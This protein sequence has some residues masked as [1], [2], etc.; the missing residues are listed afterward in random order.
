M[1]RIAVIGAGGIAR[2]VHLPSLMA[3][4]D[5]HVCAVCD[6]YIERAESA[7]AGFNA[8]CYDNYH[9][10]LEREKPDGV[11][12]LVQPDQSYRIVLDCMRFGADVFCEKPA[13]ITLFQLESLAKAQQECGTVLQIGFNRRYIPLVRAVTEKMK[14]LGG[15]IVQVGGSFFKNGDASFYSGCAS[16]LECDVI[17][18]ADLLCWFAGSEA[19]RVKA[20][21]GRVNSDVDNGWNA[22]LQFENGV[23]GTIRSN[24]QT[25][26]RTHGF[27]LH[28]PL[29]SAYIN[30]GFG[31]A[32]CE[33][34]MIYFG[35]Q[36]SFSL[37]STGTQEEHIEH[38]DGR[39][40]AGSGEYYR[41]YGY[42]D[43]DSAFVD[44]MKS[45]EAPESD[46]QSAIRAMRLTEAIMAD[47]KG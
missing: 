46:I 35:G 3:I 23:L 8:K 32:A 12:V 29:A 7:A 25:G 36:K 26:G 27:E 34:D 17:H 11:F 9:T 1:K 5:I 42:Y 43:E 41:Y 20:L 16:A 24:Y 18:V 31:T 38:F 19:Q 13:G 4:S 47:C 15:P 39:I 22:V 37:A 44:S 2:S 33:A 30:L 10:M 6:L 40:I 14:A 28:S 45:R 21:S